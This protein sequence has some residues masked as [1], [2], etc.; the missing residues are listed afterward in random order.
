MKVTK[1]LA[2]AALVV[3]A[4][5]TPSK[6]PE[7]ISVLV[8]QGAP[9]LSCISIYGSEYA[10][11]KSVSGSDIL[12]A[13][14]AKADSAY[15]VIIAPI[16]LGAKMMEKGTTKYKMEAIITWGNLY[17][18]G[19][20]DYQEGDALVAFGEAAVPG[21]ILKNAGLDNNVTYLN[22]AQDVMVQLTTGKAKA[23]LIAEPVATAA[24]AKA[25]EQG[26]TLRV[27]KDMQEAYQQV[28]N[29][30]NK[31]YPQA[32]IFV[33]EGSE[34]KAQAAL[35]QIQSFANDTAVN[36]TDEIKGLIETAGIDNLGIPSADIAVKSWTRQNINYIKASE[37][38]EEVATFLKLFNITFSQDMLSK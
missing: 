19:A 3:L 11:V 4:G 1:L 37:V 31:G 13:E 29:T 33:K 21:L 12:T 34:E 14:L 18:M 27:I 32:A 24:I 7:K 28:N 30:A 38:E 26:I 17:L 8:P 25:K 35:E 2:A 20:S 5:C 22:S 16:N 36:K 6:A 15:D 23:G 9:A 10:D